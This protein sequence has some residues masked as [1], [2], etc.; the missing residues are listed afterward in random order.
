M[1]SGRHVEGVSLQIAC[2]DAAS[3][4]SIAT[5]DKAIPAPDKI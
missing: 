1:V 5:V 3:K 2:R 4:D